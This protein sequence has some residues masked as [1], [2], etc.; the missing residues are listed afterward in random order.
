MPCRRCRWAGFAGRMAVRRQLAPRLTGFARNAT[1]QSHKLISK[2]GRG[3]P[4]NGRKTGVAPMPIE[5]AESDEPSG[6]E[7]WLTGESHH[8]SMHLERVL[9]QVQA[10][11][12]N[13]SPRGSPSDPSADH[14]AAGVE[15]CPGHHLLPLSR[16]K[17][18]VGSG[19]PL[20]RQGAGDSLFLSDCRKAFVR[21]LRPCRA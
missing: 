9:R 12:L 1:P 10:Y 7:L 16:P 4:S 19:P 2:N 11:G 13:S 5:R 17:S 8:C 6:A 20:Q 15:S 3:Q 21:P 18:F 14:P